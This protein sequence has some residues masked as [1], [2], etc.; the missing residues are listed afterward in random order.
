MENLQQQKKE[1]QYRI[2]WKQTVPDF[3]KFHN[4]KLQNAHFYF[5]RH[6]K[7]DEMGRACST[8]GCR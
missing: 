2:L 3:R 8:H 5:G 7:E 4:E 1:K 6:T